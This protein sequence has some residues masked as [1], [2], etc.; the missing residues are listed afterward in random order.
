MQ[1]EIWL[2][3]PTRQ[4]EIGT[5]GRKPYTGRLDTSGRRSKS[6]GGRLGGVCSLVGGVDPSDIPDDPA[7]EGLPSAESFL[8]TDFFLAGTPSGHVHYGD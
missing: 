6:T 5:N 8:A 2:T 3:S 7:V 4:N 1:L